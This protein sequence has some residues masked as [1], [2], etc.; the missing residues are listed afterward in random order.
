MLSLK[1]PR[2]TEIVLGPA[3]NVRPGQLVKLG[4]GL[5]CCAG[6]DRI[7][8]SLTSRGLGKAD[9]AHTDEVLESLL[10]YDTAHLSA[11]RTEGV[12]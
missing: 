2:A 1:D 12:I 9:R 11:S 3:E 6:S 7:P 10:G 8:S 4:L 5:T